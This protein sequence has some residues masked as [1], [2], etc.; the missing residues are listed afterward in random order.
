MRFHLYRQPRA[1]CSFEHTMRE[2]CPLYD[3]YRFPGGDTAMISWKKE[4]PNTGLDLTRQITAR[5][6]EPPPRARA[7]KVER[8]GSP[9]RAWI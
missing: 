1:G 7:P 9:T 3:Y 8:E 6:A 2:G 4:P 5:D